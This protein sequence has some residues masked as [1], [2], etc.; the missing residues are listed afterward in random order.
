MLDLIHSNHT[1]NRAGQP[2]DI[3][4]YQDDFWLQDTAVVEN[5][6]YRQGSWSI[7]LVFA[8]HNCPLQ[9]IKR[10]ITNFACVK[11]AELSAHYMRRL[12][13]KDQRGTLI[14]DPCPILYN[15]N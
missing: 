2:D 4:F 14:I 13:A 10:K 12:A 8:L 7:Y 15:I 6:E 3:A 11:K 5:L 1:T 9:F